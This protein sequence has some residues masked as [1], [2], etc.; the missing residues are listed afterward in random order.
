MVDNDLDVA[1][2]TSTRV[3]QFLAARRESGYT[4]CL[5]LARMALG[6]VT[7]HLPKKKRVPR[8]TT[9]AR[10]KA[11]ARAEALRGEKSLDEE[12]AKEGKNLNRKTGEI[13]L[14]DDGDHHIDP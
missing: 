9:I 4:S 11:K 12:L 8:R 10:E 5:S 3:D 14:M 2:L 7:E 1:D 6:Y 13:T